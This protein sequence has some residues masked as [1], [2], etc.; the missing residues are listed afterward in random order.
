MQLAA[1]F[2]FSFFLLG[3]K[4]KAWCKFGA[5]WAS[6]L[7]TEVYSHPFFPVYF[8]VSCMHI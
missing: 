3:F 5:Y 8:Y 6:A 4:P 2:S 7:P 1:V